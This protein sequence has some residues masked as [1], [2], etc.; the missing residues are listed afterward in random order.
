MLVVNVHQL[1]FAGSSSA[2]AHWWTADA[3]WPNIWS[4]LITL[5]FAAL[6]ASF[7]R[8]IVVQVVSSA[9]TL[10]TLAAWVWLVCS[11]TG[12]LYLPHFWRDCQVQACCSR[13]SPYHSFST[14]KL[15]TVLPCSSTGF[16]L[17][18]YSYCQGTVSGVAEATRDLRIFTPQRRLV[19][20][21]RSM[22]GY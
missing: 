10:Y 22:P 7:S 17:R 15:E 8:P 9:F 13:S 5:S 4:V 12:R 11:T 18:F 6:F 19:S 20:Y 2:V 14:C 21:A 16:C 1:M 3:N